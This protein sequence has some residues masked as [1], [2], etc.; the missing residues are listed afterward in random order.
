MLN[1]TDLLE[2]INQ[3]F[4]KITRDK[5]FNKEVENFTEHVKNCLKPNKEEDWNHI[6]TSEDIIEDS[7]YA[8]ESFL[9]FGLSGPTKYNDIGEKYLRLYGL[10]NAT[11]LQQQAILNLYLYF[12]CPNPKQIKSKIESLKIRDLRNKLGAHSTDFCDSK[13]S[14][15][16]GFVP[17]R[18]T[19]DD[20]KCDYFNNIT[21]EYVEVELIPP[22]ESH[23]KMMCS[24]YHD[25][26]VKSVKTIYK[27]NPTK[28]KSILQLAA[29]FNAMIGGSAILKDSLTGDFITINFI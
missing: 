15:I 11:Y 25:I 17:V 20:F 3:L 21:D 4:I 6:L 14:D 22:I 7:N 29:P 28:V 13:S 24:I 18:M 2:E 9:K 5:I 10:L 1:W 23:L 26:L 12:Q 19:I 16:H 27:G 8:I